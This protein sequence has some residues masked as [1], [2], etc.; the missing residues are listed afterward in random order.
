V[1][2]DRVEPLDQQPDRQHEGAATESI[3]EQQHM[4]SHAFP[5]LSEMA[6]S[7]SCSR[8][9][10]MGTS[11]SSGSGSSWTASRPTFSRMSAIAP[12]RGLWLAQ[13]PSPRCRFWTSAFV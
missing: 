11:L 9:M 6:V 5:H 2:S 3:M 10:P 13:I 7:S 1:T 12:R 8:D 4:M